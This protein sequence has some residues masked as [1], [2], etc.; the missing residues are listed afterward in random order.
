M[1]SEMVKV[2]F[3]MGSSHP[4]GIGRDHAAEVCTCRHS[5]MAAMR[6]AYSYSA[7]GLSIYKQYSRSGFPVL[8]AQGRVPA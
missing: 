3:D 2:E 1:R 5:P 8:P 6:A 4:C 7:N